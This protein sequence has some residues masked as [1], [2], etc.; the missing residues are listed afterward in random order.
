MGVVAGNVIEK[1]NEKTGIAERFRVV[2][3]PVDP[4]NTVIRRLVPLDTTDEDIPV[5]SRL[6]NEMESRGILERQSAPE[7]IIVGDRVRLRTALDSNEIPIDGTVDSKL[8]SGKVHVRF[9]NGV[10]GR[11][12]TKEL[13][14]VH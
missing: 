9:E 1:V 5:G 14:K 3:I 11:Y 12:E 2:E 8:K 4:P 13:V 7:R 10:S 6:M